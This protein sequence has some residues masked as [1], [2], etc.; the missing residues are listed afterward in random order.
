MT[1]TRRHELPESAAA[2]V[3]RHLSSTPSRFNWVTSVQFG[4]ALMAV[5]PSSGIRDPVRQCFTRVGPKKVRGDLDEEPVLHL[6]TKRPHPSTR[7]EWFQNA[8]ESLEELSLPQALSGDTED[9]NPMLE[10][11]VEKCLSLCRLSAH[12]F[13]PDLA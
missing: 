5:H 1:S 4:D 12:P 10:A 2:N 8:G 3:V 6:P 9:L 11:L 7:T 13:P